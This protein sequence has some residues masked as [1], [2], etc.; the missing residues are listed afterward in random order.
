MEKPT[1]SRI[2]NLVQEIV[3]GKLGDSQLDQCDLTLAQIAAIKKSFVFTLT[4]MLHARIAYPQDENRSKQQ[5][6]KTQG[7]PAEDQTS[8]GTARGTS[9]G[10]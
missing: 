2:E 8:S 10:A 4:N 3:D 1:A 5:A 6:G 9:P 7:A